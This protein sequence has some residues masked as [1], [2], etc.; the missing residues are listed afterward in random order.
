MFKKIVKI[1]IMLTFLNIYSISYT[2][3]SDIEVLRQTNNVGKIVEFLISNTNYISFIPTIFPFNGEYVVTSEY[4][5]R[6]HPVKKTFTKHLGIDFNC[7]IGTDVLSTANGKVIKV[8]KHHKINGNSITISHIGNYET[9]YCHLKTIDVKVNDLVKQGQKIGS[10]GN[11][12]RSSG[13]HL[14]YGIKHNSR[15]INPIKFCFI[16]NDIM[17]FLNTLKNSE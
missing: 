15:F 2:Q 16:K 7:P 1:N 3:N 14:H 9:I 17:L 10:S 6:Y 12:G 4:S 13:A 8:Q 11:T 5:Y